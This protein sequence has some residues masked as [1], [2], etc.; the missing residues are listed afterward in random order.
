MNWLSRC[1]PGSVARP[2]TTSLVMSR[3]SSSGTPAW[4]GGSPGSGQPELAVRQ[5]RECVS[6]S[7]NARSNRCRHDDRLPGGAGF[8]SAGCLVRLGSF[9][10]LGAGL[11]EPTD[12]HDVRVRLAGAR[13]HDDLFGRATAQTGRGLA[14]AAANLVLTSGLQPT[15]GPRTGRRGRRS[16][17]QP[18][19][20]S[21]LTDISGLAGREQRQ[22]PGPR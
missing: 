22:R 15:N 5:R 18:G 4:A 3:G 17:Q 6:A 11:P 13:T 21:G 2:V 1:A 7:C 10:G 12:R 8:P 19:E 16:L 20:H 9:L 14:T